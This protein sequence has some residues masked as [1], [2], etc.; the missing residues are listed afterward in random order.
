AGFD[1]RRV[2]CDCPALGRKGRI[3]K[4]QPAIDDTDLHAF[5]DGA[6]E[7]ARAR[8]VEA[9]LQSNPAL[10][11][12]LAAFKSDKDLLKNVYGPLAD[13]PLPKQWIAQARRRRDK[14]LRQGGGPAPRLRGGRAGGDACPGGAP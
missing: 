7:P 2:Q 3:M 14:D 13:R 12:R 4:D 6:L 10:A 1:G 9:E 11:A 5:L 8:A